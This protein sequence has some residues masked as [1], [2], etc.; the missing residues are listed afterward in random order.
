MGRPSSYS[1]DIAETI[2]TMLLTE[3]MHQICQR[4]GFPARSTVTRW[5]DEQPD[6]AQRCAR[7]DKYRGDTWAAL[8]AETARACHEEN[9]Q[10]S[11]VKISAYQW[12]AS[13]ENAKYADRNA[14]TGAD[15]GAI[16][17]KVE[18]EDVAAK[19]AARLA[20]R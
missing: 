2:C 6:F 13:K 14:I 20:S 10:S 1:D 3:N 8:V 16:E 5:L 15:G 7:A 12:L 17:V 19:L 18:V 11:K 4:E 9:A